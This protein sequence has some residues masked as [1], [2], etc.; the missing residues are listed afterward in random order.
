TFRIDEN[1]IVRV[2]AKDLGT[3]RVTEVKVTPT[4]G[5]TAD[6][7]DRLVSDGERFKQ[8][9]ALR[10]ELADLRN[11]ADT[12]AYTTEQALEGYSDLLDE[13]VILEIRGDCVTLRRLLDGGGDLEALRAAYARLEGAAFRIAESMYGGEEGGAGSG[14]TPA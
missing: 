3:N 13:S 9:D 6:E 12:L 2:E 7:V 14:E 1:G 4:S 8:T 10:R 11:Q 5:L